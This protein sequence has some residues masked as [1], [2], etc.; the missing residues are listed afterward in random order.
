MFG[1]LT[2]CGG[3][4]RQP[5]PCIWFGLLTLH[6]FHIPSFVRLCVLIVLELV[7]F[8]VF[9]VCHFIILWFPYLRLCILSFGWHWFYIWDWDEFLNVFLKQSF[10]F[11]A[12][13]KLDDEED[14]VDTS[15]WCSQAASWGAITTREAEPIFLLEAWWQWRMVSRSDVFGRVWCREQQWFWV[16]AQ[17]LLLAQT[18][19]WRTKRKMWH[20]YVSQIQCSVIIGVTCNNCV[21]LEWDSVF[22]FHYVG[23]LLWPL[24]E[25]SGPWC[26]EPFCAHCEFWCMV[27][28]Q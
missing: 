6:V 23:P 14:F 7:N 22:L 8:N 12:S 13:L 27:L 24:W 1:S 11:L 19:N 5:K 10:C 26:R 16:W 18:L 20:S 25:S 9:G 17:T 3:C 15:L 21:T 28:K 2:I 4:A